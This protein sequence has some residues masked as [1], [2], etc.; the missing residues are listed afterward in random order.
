MG[1]LSA[2]GLGTR[3]KVMMRMEGAELRAVGGGTWTQT[4]AQGRPPTTIVLEESD[5][6]YEVTRL[7]L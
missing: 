3:S 6:S 1:L 4:W 2:V 7:H 5:M